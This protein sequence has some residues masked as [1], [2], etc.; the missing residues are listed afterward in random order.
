MPRKK[1]Q[2]QE[3]S[4]S[5]Q[6]V[7]VLCVC[8]GYFRHFA[9]W[10]NGNGLAFPELF[11]RNEIPTKQ[12]I[13]FQCKRRREVAF[14]IQPCA[15]INDF[16]LFVAGCPFLHT[17]FILSFFFFF[18]RKRSDM[19][20]C[21]KMSICLN[22]YHWIENHNGYEWERKETIQITGCRWLMFWLVFVWHCCKFE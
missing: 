1:Q 4:K 22:C 2:Q 16:F 13:S 7:S 20:S 21:E 11:V 9:F 17:L 15:V 10:S 19:K 3:I 8:L 5:I 14:A 12:P 18:R 6:A